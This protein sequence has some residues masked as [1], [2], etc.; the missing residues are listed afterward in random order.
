VNNGWSTTTLISYVP[1]LSVD[2]MVLIK[3]ILYQRLCPIVRAA[4][5]L[6]VRPSCP[7]CSPAHLL[8]DVR[9]SISS[10]SLSVDPDHAEEVEQVRLAPARNVGHHPPLLEHP[11]QL[12]RRL[13]GDIDPLSVLKAEEPRRRATPPELPPPSQQRRHAA[14][15]GGGLHVAG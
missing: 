8:F 14:A 3:Q 7:A 6:D 12:R 13:S 1:S 15:A 9:P 10:A 2:D 5:Q 11:P 4:Q